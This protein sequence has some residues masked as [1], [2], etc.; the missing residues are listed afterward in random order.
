MNEGAAGQ[1]PS[2]QPPDQHVLPV[3]RADPVAM[4][5]TPESML[6]PG[7]VGALVMM[8]TNALANNFHVSR[9]HTALL[10]S[11]ICGFLVLVADNQL[12]KKCIYYA[13]NSLV[14]FC[15][16]VGSGTVATPDKQA[17][18]PSLIGI[19]HAQ[20]NDNAKM[21]D[22]IKAATEKVQGQQSSLSGEQTEIIRKLCENPNNQL[23]GGPNSVVKSPWDTR[24]LVNGS[25]S[26]G[27]CS[28]FKNP[29][30]HGC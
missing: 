6:T 4:F 26:G 29:F 30:G 15:V 12:W 11:L 1:E 22:C 18:I 19:A 21:N 14:I 7:V 5:L 2:H 3:N 23:L 13:L 17:S 8:I 16:A 27:T 20:S 25:I 24:N 10:F 9:P 28:F